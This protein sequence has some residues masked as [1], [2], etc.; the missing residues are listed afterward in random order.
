MPKI[1]KLFVALII[2]FLPLTSFCNKQPLVSLQCEYLSNP[3]GI[4]VEH[5]RLMWH[6]N[7]KKPQQ[8]QAY[9]IIVANSLEE[10]NT[11]SALVW[12]SG[13]IKADD[14][15]VYYEG[16]PLMAHKRY[17][18]KV[19][20]WTAGKKIVSKPTWFETAKIA[21]CLVNSSNIEDAALKNTPKTAKI[22]YIQKKIVDFFCFRRQKMKCRASSETLFPKA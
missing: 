8:Q 9:R 19:E 3:L 10:L 15:M 7:S 4:D 14:Q 20:I 11:D 17:Y 1:Y 21:S 12:D 13:K 5:P 22:G 16:A 6:M 18:W 2:A